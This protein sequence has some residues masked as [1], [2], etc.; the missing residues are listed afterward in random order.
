MTHKTTTMAT[1]DLYLYNGPLRRMVPFA[2]VS[3]E[4]GRVTLRSATVC[5]RVV[6]PCMQRRASNAGGVEVGGEG[7]LGA[8]QVWLSPPPSRC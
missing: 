1:I 5:L 6:S 2:E 7:V 4:Q 3:V 8:E